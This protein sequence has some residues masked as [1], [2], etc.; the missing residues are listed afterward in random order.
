MRPIFSTVIRRQ[1]VPSPD[2]SPSLTVLRYFEQIIGSPADLH[3]DA[4]RALN[5]TVRCVPHL[6]RL[7]YLWRRQGFT[8][9]KASQRK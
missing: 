9:R 4:V 8:G 7:G 1:S 6:L 2:E 3:V 5:D